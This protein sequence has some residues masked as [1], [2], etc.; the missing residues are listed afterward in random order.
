M[1]YSEN[2]YKEEKEITKSSTQFKVNEYLELRLKGKDTIIYVNGE[3]FEQCKFLLLDIPINEIKSLDEIESIDEAAEKLNHSLEPLEHERVDGVP[4]RVE[5]WGHCSN[6]QVWAENGYDTHLIHS[7]LAF[8]L[9]LKLSNVGDPLAKKVFKEEIVKRFLSGNPSV[10][11]YLFETN[12]LAYL[13]D[14]EYED[15]FEELELKG[16]KKSFITYGRRIIAFTN[17]DKLFL[18]K[19]NLKKNHNI[20]NVHITDITKIKGLKNQTN[21]VKLDI[22]GHG[23]TEIKNLEKFK[24]LKNLNLSSNQITEINGLE[25]LVNLKKL[26]LSGNRITKLKGLEKLLNLEK[27]NLMG[28]GI[29]QIDGL[30]NLTNLKTLNLTN[31]KVFKIKNLENL[32]NLEELYLTRNNISEIKN[33]EML[34]NLKKLYL[35]RNLI[36][37]IKGLDNLINL[38][39]LSLSYNKIS[40]IEG[41]DN[42]KKVKEIYLTGNPISKTEGYNIEQLDKNRDKLINL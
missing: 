16:I 15:M 3:R 12:Y 31:N 20:N 22:S 19:Y 41:L 40:K 32:V 18:S 1:N 4:P 36:L 17:Y 8:P 14:E 35:A 7:N 9:L 34:V 42:L 2:K 28:N 38:R 37:E 26:E 10:M 27:L 39:K 13:N 30:E 29:K 21:L 23:I 11:Q 25:N 6:L 5:F 33:L 24:N